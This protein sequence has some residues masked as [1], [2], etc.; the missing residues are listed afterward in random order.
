MHRLLP[1]I[2]LV[3]LLAAC[4]GPPEESGPTGFWGEPVAGLA[5]GL[6]PP[7]TSFTVEE[8]MTFTVR[9]KNVGA[10]PL[11]LG[12]FE[13]HMWWYRLKFVSLDGGP[14]FDAANTELLD[15]DKPPDRTLQSGELWTKE[16]ALTKEGRFLRVIPNRKPGDDWDYRDRLP[17]GRY[18]V[19][20]EYAWTRAEPRSYWTGRARSNELELEI[21]PAP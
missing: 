4:G 8:A 6:E 13:D 5:L 14:D 1:Q 18:R 19:V 7:Q 17:P 20:L 16:L 10:L 12:H 11:V 2:A 9:A 3:A 21:T 15:F